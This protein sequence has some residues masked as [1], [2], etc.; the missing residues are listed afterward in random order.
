MADVGRKTGR[1]DEPRSS[2]PRV[3]EGFVAELT[4]GDKVDRYRNIAA[5]ACSVFHR[6]DE[7]GKAAARTVPPPPHRWCR[8]RRRPLGVC[9]MARPRAVL[10]CALVVALAGCG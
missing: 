6:G 4:Y 8:R 9:L 5:G 10:A 7:Y 3:P 2:W 1:T